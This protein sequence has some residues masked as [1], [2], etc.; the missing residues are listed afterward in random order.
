MIQK[1]TVRLTIVSAWTYLP[2]GSISKLIY[3]FITGIYKFSYVCVSAFSPE[4]LVYLVASPALSSVKTNLDSLTS[5]EIA[6]EK[7][8]CCLGFCDW[9]KSL[10]SIQRLREIYNSLCVFI[11]TLEHICY[12]P[13]SSMQQADEMNSSKA[14]F[15]KDYQ[16]KVPSFYTLSMWVHS[17]LNGRFNKRKNVWVDKLLLI[18]SFTIFGH[19]I[20]EIGWCFWVVTLIKVVRSIQ[21]FLYISHLLTLLYLL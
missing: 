18:C 21:L 7:K 2:S 8:I 12:E 9:F 1:R 14:S 16:Q 19:L 3:E 13:L 20:T 17:E 11:K 6:S 5:E 4:V 15:S 10:C